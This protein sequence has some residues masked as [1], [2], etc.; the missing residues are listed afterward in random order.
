MFVF[1]IIYK[2]QILETVT[3]HIAQVIDESFEEAVNKLKAYQSRAILSGFCL[4]K[5]FEVYPCVLNALSASEEAF[6]ALTEDSQE[7]SHG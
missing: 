2:K 7:H 6:N 1:E 5:K 4:L 3:F